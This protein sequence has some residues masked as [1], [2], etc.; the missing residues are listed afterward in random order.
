MVNGLESVSTPFVAAT[1]QGALQGL[2]TFVAIDGKVYRLLG[3]TTAERFG[4]YQDAFERSHASFARLTDPRYLNVQPK[5]IQ[6]VEVPR[7]MPLP[8]FAQRYPSNVPLKSLAVLNN[9]NEQERIPAGTLAK[10][11]VGGNLPQ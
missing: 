5:R 7:E 11:V 1:E 9:V 8:D 10:R 6:I 2:A 4:R 3:Y